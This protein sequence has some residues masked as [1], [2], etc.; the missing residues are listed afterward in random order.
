M[1]FQFALVPG[2]RAIAWA[3]ALLVG[4]WVLARRPDAAGRAFAFWALVWAG[5]VQLLLS[6]QALATD[7]A[8]QQVLYRAANYAILFSS[9]AFLAVLLYAPRPQPRRRVALAA[10][11][12][13]PA[14][15]ALAFAWDHG[16]FLAETLD[17]GY[18]A[19]NAGAY[20]LAFH[21]VLWTGFLVGMLW[22]GWRAPALEG[23][24]R[25]SATWLMAGL[26]LFAADRFTRTATWWVREPS[27]I[28]PPPDGPIYALYMVAFGVA[29][30]W[31][32]LRARRIPDGANVGLAA[33]VGGAVGATGIITYGLTDPQFA[34]T[35]AG[36][37]LSAL[38]APLY[39]LLLAGGA[40]DAAGSDAVVHARRQRAAVLSEP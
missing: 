11:I 8:T 23:S 1:P 14:L 38:L 6:L 35:T 28:G 5:G 36:V 7:A 27:T 16:A 19:T 18:S 2:L 32:A 37:L 22:L 39:T 10:L 34:G 3:A 24:A 13:L 31:M 29:V 40:L 26:A 25:A 15:A 30:A 20:A 33:L 4:L 12:A 17:G 21:P 9:S